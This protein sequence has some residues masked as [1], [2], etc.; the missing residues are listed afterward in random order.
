M[1]GSE[2]IS[3]FAIGRYDLTS[4]KSLKIGALFFKE[5]TRWVI[6]IRRGNAEGEVIGSGTIAPLD[7]KVYDRTSIMLKSSRGFADL[8][9]KIQPEQKTTAEFRL[10]DISFE[11]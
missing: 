10:Q 6:E 11:K 3:G 7:L 2:G 8:Y 4:V 9:I 1:L 5:R